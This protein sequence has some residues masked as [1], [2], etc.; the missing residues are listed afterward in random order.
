MPLGVVLRRAPGV[1]R[2]ASVAWRMTGVIPFAPAPGRV[3][4]DEGGVRE[5]HAATLPLTL[6]R[7]DSEAYM[8]GLSARAPQ[9][10]CAM[11]SGSGEPVPF[12]VTASPFEAQDWADGAD[13]VLRSVSMP[14]AL[15]AWVEAFAFAHHE[16]ERFVKR[17]RS[18]R[19]D[20]AAQDGIG[21]ARVAQPADIWRSPAS[22]RA[23]SGS[24]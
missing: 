18:P 12:A 2:W 19:E 10:W 7:A 15:R 17:R 3:L 9:V 24:A 23:R 8:Q 13:D 5:V 16:E 14:E 20:G 1:T 22:L 21:D 6:H 4:L 11:R